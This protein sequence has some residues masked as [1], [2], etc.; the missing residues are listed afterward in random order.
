MIKWLVAF[1]FGN[2]PW[3]GLGC[4]KLNFW[5]RKLVLGCTSLGPVSGGFPFGRSVFQSSQTHRSYRRF[6]VSERQSLF[7]FGMLRVLEA[8]QSNFQSDLDLST[9]QIWSIGTDQ[10]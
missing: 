6:F 10:S 2:A 3:Q 8:P 7:S 4:Q 5:N 1:G 9:I